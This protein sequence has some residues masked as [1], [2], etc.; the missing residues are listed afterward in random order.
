[1]SDGVDRWI[2]SQAPFGPMKAKY[3]RITH[4]TCNTYFTATVYMD[5]SGQYKRMVLKCVAAGYPM[6]A[7]V[8]Q[9]KL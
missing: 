3:D 7:P 4:N 6:Y 1:M 2:Q 5:G 9:C 8:C